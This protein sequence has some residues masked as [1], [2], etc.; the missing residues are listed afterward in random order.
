M[1][2]VILRHGKSV[3]YFEFLSWDSEFFSRPS[4]LLDAGKSSLIPS[5]KI[6]ALITKKFKGC[7]LTARIDSSVS[8]EVIGFLQAC[9]FKY[10]CTEVTLMWDGRTCRSTD[11]K[12]ESLVTEIKQ[13]NGLPC[14]E[15]GSVFRFSRFHCDSNI[16]KRKADEV[17]VSYL[18][19]YKPGGARH[20]Y[21]ISDTRGEIMG[22]VLV[23]EDKKKHLANLFFVAVKGKFRGK[24]AGGAMLNYISRRFKGYKIITGTQTVNVEALNFYIKNGFSRI[25]ESKAILHR[26][27]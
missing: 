8:S 17:W 27:S 22:T 16:P 24:G 26:W 21:V 6:K 14:Q 3:F 18:E 19:N 1:K 15:L 7:F 20:C 25:E 11:I 4:F 9:L 2:D 5:L 12:Q 23:N 10:V 13:T